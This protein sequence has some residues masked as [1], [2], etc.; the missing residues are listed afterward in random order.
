MIR[1]LQELT[2]WE[3]KSAPLGVMAGASVPR[4]SLRLK[5]S[6]TD[7]LFR[8]A[9]PPAGGQHTRHASFKD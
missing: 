3:E 5:K 9:K 2:E 4:S 6:R 8:T 1:K 7:Y